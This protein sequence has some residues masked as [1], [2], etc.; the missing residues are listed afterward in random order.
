[1]NNINSEKTYILSVE[2][3]KDGNAAAR[4]E[5][6]TIGVGL[7]TVQYQLNRDMVS[8]LTKLQYTAIRNGNMTEAVKAGKT[9]A[10]VVL[11]KEIRDGLPEENSNLLLSTNEHNI[12]WELLYDSEY[13]D[14][15]GI[16]YA[17]G[18]R[19]I[20]SGNAKF[21]DE[22]TNRRN[23]LILTN[24]TEDLP[25]AQKE[26]VKLMKF[27]RSCGFSCTLITGR[28]ITSADILIQLCSGEFG[29][30]HYSGHIGHDEKGSYLKLSGDDRFY[31]KETAFIDDFGQPFI[32]LNGCGGGPEWGGSADI[33]TP[34]IYSGSGPIL[35]AAM[36]VSDKGARELSESIMEKVLGGATFG[37]AV[38][39]T[40][41]EF[42]E[43]GTDWMSFVLYG[44]PGFCISNESAKTKSESIM[45]SQNIGEFTASVKNILAVADAVAGEIWKISTSHLFV[46]L[47]A[48]EDEEIS[49]VFVKAGVLPEEVQKVIAS[50]FPNPLLSSVIG[51][52][53]ED[54]RYSPNTLSAIRK[55]RETATINKRAVLPRDLFTALLSSP[56][57]ITELL[58]TIDID[59]E[60]LLKYL[61][62]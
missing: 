60:D 14:F 45:V 61:D 24:P 29:I 46:S 19:L 22:V 7:K 13:N 10:N 3:N 56:N 15:Y 30:I 11:P 12:P 17:M 40:R 35:C 57:Y 59:S 4:I 49:Q 28:Q 25:E 47:I 62:D 9:L 31:L 21:S 54:D 2:V 36:P 18:R 55:A 43:R 53:P 44:N 58:K 8:N 26:A 38:M 20:I 51:G 23:C 42:K 41:R 50:N 33:V 52:I 37:D 27:F 1:M 16:K 32:F 39:E 48:E 5:D 34:L 6:G